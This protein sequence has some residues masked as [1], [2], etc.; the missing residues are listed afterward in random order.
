MLRQCNYMGNFKIRSYTKKELAMEYFPA[1][2]SPHTAVN[3][4]MVWIRRCTPL[5]EELR[6]MGMV[7]TAKCFTPREVEVIVKYIG[8]PP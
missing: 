1:C 5:Y 3:H 2:S 7:H 6:R 8:E 4:L